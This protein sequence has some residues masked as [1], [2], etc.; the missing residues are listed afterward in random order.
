M[1]M[2]PRQSPVAFLVAFIATA[3]F[4][5]V[6]GWLYGQEFVPADKLLRDADAHPPV[7][8]PVG[9]MS[10]IH[11]L[12]EYD[13]QIRIARAEVEIWKRRVKR[14]SSWHNIENAQ[15][16]LMVAKERLRQLIIAKTEFV[17]SF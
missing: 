15:I 3:L 14:Y 5:L 8:R 16:S 10:Y 17:K 12:Q 1:Y 11:R 4:F 2:P 9:D 7:L 13:A 6:W